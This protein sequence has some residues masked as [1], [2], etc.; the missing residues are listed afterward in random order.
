MTHD[1][2][3]GPHAPL[4][5]FPPFSHL[6]HLEHMPPAAPQPMHQLP[7]QQQMG[8]NPLLS[9]AFAAWLQYMQLQLHLQQQQQQSTN[10]PQQP[11]PSQPPHPARPQQSPQGH[12]PFPLSAFAP[13][14]SLSHLTH[15]T[16]APSGYTR[17]SPPQQTAPS[18]TP[19]PDAGGTDTDMDGTAMVEEKRRRNTAASGTFSLVSNMY[20]HCSCAFFSFLLSL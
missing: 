14:P 17:L 8:A 9:Q 3:Q 5:S 18:N 19:S 16:N 11:H 12:S 2:H 15:T 13:P 1:Q 7:D 4:Q 20:S 10:I 6:P